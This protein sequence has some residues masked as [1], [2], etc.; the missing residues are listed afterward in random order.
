MPNSEAE[1][2]LAN[3]ILH[4]A[5][6]AA[7]K[8]TELGFIAVAGWV[9]YEEGPHILKEGKA[10]FQHLFQHVRNRNRGDVEHDQ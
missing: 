7:K 10:H 6:F 9:L 3:E 8:V 5:W 4:D 2:S 1:R